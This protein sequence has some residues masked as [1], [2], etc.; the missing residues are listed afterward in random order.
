MEGPNEQ[1]FLLCGHRKRDSEGD[2][3][4]LPFKRFQEQHHSSVVGSR[5]VVRRSPLDLHYTQIKRK[6]PG[7]YTVP[8]DSR[9]SVVGLQRM[10]CCTTDCS[11]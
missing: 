1:A 3:C 2:L 9:Q 4:Q 5:V 6:G 8:G 11:M 7:E 10:P